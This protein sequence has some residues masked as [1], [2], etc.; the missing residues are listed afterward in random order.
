MARLV[1]R[2]SDAMIRILSENQME[3]G[4][5]LVKS[6]TDIGAVFISF[7]FLDIGRLSHRRLEKVH[8]EVWG[9]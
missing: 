8:I 2:N 4:Y 9:A 1:S 3:E 6:K 5:V 7:G